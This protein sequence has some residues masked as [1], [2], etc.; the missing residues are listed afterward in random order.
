M[1]DTFPSYL[2]RVLYRLQKYRELD[3]CAL[4]AT[5]R[6]AGALFG[7]SVKKTAKNAAHSVIVTFRYGIPVRIF[8]DGTEE[9]DCSSP[10]MKASGSSSII[11]VLRHMAKSLLSVTPSPFAPCPTM[12]PRGKPLE[13]AFV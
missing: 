7:R 9:I 13:P 12:R 2:S 8:P 6:G 1:D 10:E 3:R 11:G 5:F 4:I